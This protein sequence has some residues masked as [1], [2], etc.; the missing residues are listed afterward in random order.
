MSTARNQK[1]NC[2]SCKK[3]IIANAKFCNYCGTS[4]SNDGPTLTA[5]EASDKGASHIKDE[6]EQLGIIFKEGKY[7]FENLSYESREDAIDSAQ[8]KKRDISSLPDLRTKENDHPKNN[9]GLFFG[10]G[11]ILLIIVFFFF[12]INPANKTSNVTKGGAIVPKD[13]SK[14][15]P[16]STEFPVALPAR[17]K[18]VAEC[19]VV[20][21]TMGVYNKQTGNIADGDTLLNYALAWGQTA[22]DIGAT[23]GVSAEAVK[24]E[25]KRLSA[26]VAS[27][28][29]AFMQTAPTK[30]DSCVALLRSDSQILSTWQRNRN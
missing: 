8:R 9:S 24:A 10:I 15:S 29:A 23:E 13:Q 22:F 7:F 21:M 6:L 27:N 17:T 18:A 16:K 14:N 1:M 12:L 5:S 19:A 30:M 11:G 3:S 4:Q 28:M 20:T 26:N 25:N 2:L